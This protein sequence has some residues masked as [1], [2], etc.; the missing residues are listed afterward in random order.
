MRT[1][2]L[3]NFRNTAFAEERPP[4]ALPDGRRV[5]SYEYSEIATSGRT[6][7]R[8]LQLRTEDG[9]SIVIDKVTR[10]PAEEARISH[11]RVTAKPSARTQSEM[12]RRF[13]QD[14]IKIT[15]GV[16]S[17]KR[18]L[19]L[20]HDILGLTLESETRDS[21]KFTNGL[22]LTAQTRDSI[23]NRLDYQAGNSLVTILTQDFHNV[24]DRVR[25]SDLAQILH[26]DGTDGREQLRIRDPD[27]HNLQILSIP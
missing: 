5:G 24:A 15:L 16:G 12:E 8:R 23:E 19:R 14:I 4:G 21:V 9:Q 2:D 1:A 25:S 18:S 3:D 17:L 26:Y 10:R 11:P 22:A 27:G 13:R 20:Y 6:E 7:V